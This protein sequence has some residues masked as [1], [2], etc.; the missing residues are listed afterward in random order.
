MQI[1]QGI[2]MNGY[3]KFNQE[4]KRQPFKNINDQGRFRDNY[5]FDNGWGNFDPTNAL[6]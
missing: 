6:Y 5:P 3:E 2:N 1:L 4:S